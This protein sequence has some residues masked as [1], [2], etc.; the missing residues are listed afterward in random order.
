M[1]FFGQSIFTE[2]MAAPPVGSETYRT[3]LATAK[4]LAAV[5]TST[6]L[7][8]SSGLFTWTCP[9]FTFELIGATLP[10]VPREREGL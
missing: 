5:P 1:R 7:R 6:T 9:L 8:T 4:R 10:L 3:A 2:A